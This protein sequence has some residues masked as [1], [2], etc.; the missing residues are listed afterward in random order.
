MK[1]TD[2]DRRSRGDPVR[3]VRRLQDS[4]KQ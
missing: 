2:A 4:R 3:A 1:D